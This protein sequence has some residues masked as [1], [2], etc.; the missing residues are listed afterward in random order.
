MIGAEDRKALRPRW[1]ARSLGK[2]PAA[3]AESAILVKIIAKLE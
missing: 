3:T 2:T 1:K